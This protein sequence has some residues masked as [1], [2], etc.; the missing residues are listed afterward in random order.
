MLLVVA[1]CGRVGFDAHGPASDG[2]IVD[3]AGSGVPATFVPPWHSGPRMRARLL[4]GGGDPIFYG[5]HDAQLATDCQPAIASDGMERC[6]PLSARADL[7]FS[8]AGCTQPLAARYVGNCGHDSYAYVDSGGVHEYPIGAAYAGT[9]YDGPSG[10]VPTTPPASIEV[11]VLGAEVAPS[12]FVTSTYHHQTVG[13]YDHSFNDFS[14]GTTIDIGLLSVDNIA[15]TPT[16]SQ[17]GQ[18]R[19]QAG[20]K[21]GVPAYSDA[22]CTQ[23]ILVWNRTQYDPPSTSM[24]AVFGPQ[25]CESSYSLYTVI[26]D[27]TAA[28]YYEKVNGS[29]TLLASTSGTRLYTVQPLAD[30]SP[31]GTVERGPNRGR[32]GTF[33]WVGPDNVAIPTGNFDQQSGLP[34]TPFNA[35]DGKLRCLPSAETGT[36]GNENAT[37]SGTA[38]V[39]LGQCYGAPPVDGP[40]YTSCTDTGW[41]V[42]VLTTTVS[43]ASLSFDGTCV[44]IDLPG[45]VGYQRGVTGSEIDPTTFPALTE[46]IE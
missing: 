29:C 7:Y 6:M 46:M 35:T 18:V 8:D 17:L 33:Y 3:G 4:I 1:A 31:V 25:V 28:Q 34:C 14:D 44:Q 20:A 41:P 36:S 21:I 32:I 27:V 42:H 13:A 9:V 19:C 5:W 45:G 16:A 38:Q 37:C 39:I 2:A 15:C 12:T 22:G 23:P 10:C 11:H 30:P 26:A 43:S 24:L 40:T